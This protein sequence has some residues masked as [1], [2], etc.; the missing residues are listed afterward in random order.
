MFTEACSTPQRKLNA[1]L[2]GQIE[3]QQRRIVTKPIL[4]KREERVSHTRHFFLKAADEVLLQVCRDSLEST[5]VN[6]ADERRWHVTERPHVQS[7]LGRWFDLW[8]EW[9]GHFKWEFRD[10]FQSFTTTRWRS[11]IFGRL[12]L[13]ILYRQHW[14]IESTTNSVDRTRKVFKTEQ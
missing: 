1:V 5:K 3:Q 7:A 11:K 9:K 6:K 13:W 12:K 10:F 4:M 8:N 14:C 2:S